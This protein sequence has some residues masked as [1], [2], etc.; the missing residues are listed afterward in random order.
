MGGS[1][2]PQPGGA[3]LELDAESVLQERPNERGWGLT[4]VRWEELVEEWTGVSQ[5]D[6]QMSSAECP[7][8]FGERP[9]SG[10]DPE[11][12]PGWPEE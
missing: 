9:S 4:G 2:V 7:C 1:E 8:D 3:A 6:T 10:E 11:D 5:L 12:G